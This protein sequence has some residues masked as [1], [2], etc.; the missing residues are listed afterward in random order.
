VIQTFCARETDAE[1]RRQI[2]AC[3]DA[4]ER[5]ARLLLHL[6]ATKRPPGADPDKDTALTITHADLASM[7]ALSRPHVSVLM[8][9]FRVR[10]LVSYGRTGPLRIA[11][12][13]L[14]R[15]LDDDRLT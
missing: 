5:L 10:R 11:T 6:P 12:M 1:Q 4:R 14:Q 3:R 8:T 2:H 7:A 13:R 15:A 9:E